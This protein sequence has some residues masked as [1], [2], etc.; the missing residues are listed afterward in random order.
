MLATVN[1]EIGQTLIAQ[2]LA[3]QQGLGDSGDTDPS[4]NGLAG[5]DPEAGSIAGGRPADLSEAAYRETSANANQAYG[6]LSDIRAR[7]ERDTVSG[8]DYLSGIREGN[9]RRN[10]DKSLDVTNGTVVTLSLK[11]G[12]AKTVTV[13]NTDIAHIDPD[14]G[15]SRHTKVP[16]GQR[17]IITAG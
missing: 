1:P 4:G 17:Y 16:F 13:T 6:E 5:P 9:V 14:T 8:K 11:D 10:G 3:G 12:R 15:G 7:D 2:G